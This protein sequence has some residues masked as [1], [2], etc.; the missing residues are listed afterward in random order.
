MQKSAGQVWFKPKRFG[1]GASPASWQGWLV[2]AIFLVLTTLVALL[3]HGPPRRIIAA[4][5]TGGFIVIAY[6]KTDGG[7]HWRW[8]S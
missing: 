4:A 3:S 6:V 7:W 2:T 5:L 8:L 1:Y